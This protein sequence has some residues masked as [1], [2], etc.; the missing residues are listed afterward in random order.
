MLL[1]FLRHIV[2]T[3]KIFK[4]IFSQKPEPAPGKKIPGAEAA[5]KQDGSETLQLTTHSIR[6]TMHR[7]YSCFLTRPKMPVA[8]GTDGGG[9]DHE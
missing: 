6:Q 3:T 9:E 7:T 5:S 2:N 1:V 8:S 4:K